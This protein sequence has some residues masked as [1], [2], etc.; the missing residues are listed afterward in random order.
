MFVLLQH[1]SAL[2][3]RDESLLAELVDLKRL[4]FLWVVWID[5]CRDL[6]LKVVDNTLRRL[7]DLGSVLLDTIVKLLKHVLND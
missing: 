2:L 5:L 6:K 4:V 7:F 1:V 3:D